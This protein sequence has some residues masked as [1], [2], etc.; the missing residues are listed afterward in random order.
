MC[1]GTARAVFH[2]PTLLFYKH[3]GSGNMGADVVACHCCSTIHPLATLCNIAAV[4]LDMI[5]CECPEPG[6]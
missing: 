3:H 2:S 5:T 4:R 1:V 6:L